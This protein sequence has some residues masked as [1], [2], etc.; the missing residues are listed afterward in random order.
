MIIERN[1]TVPDNIVELDRHES[2]GGYTRQYGKEI[3]SLYEDLNI[4]ILPHFPLELDIS[5]I[6]ALRFP[7]EM[8][9]IGTANGLEN[10][11]VKRSG[12]NFSIDNEHIMVHAVGDL[13]TAVY[14][15][16]L[17]ASVNAQIRE[18]IRAFFPMYHSIK[19]RNLTWRLT[20]IESGGMHLDTFGEGART[21]RDKRY[22]RIKFFINLDN[23]PRKWWTSHTLSETLK[24]ARG[25]LPDELPD[26]INYVNH[27]INTSGVMEDLPYHTIKYPALSAVFGNAEAICHAVRYGKRM[28]AGEY[29]CDASDMLDPEKFTYTRIP[30]WLADADIGVAS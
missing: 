10:G 6:Q 28:V 23:E 30:K 1:K 22:H 15:Q 5:L 16:A 12:K 29:L 7:E 2:I 19:L 13:K 25:Q 24:Q 18:A 20:P 3:A 9:K 21:P 14:I 11:I 26:D 17:I 27:L 4:I 8:A